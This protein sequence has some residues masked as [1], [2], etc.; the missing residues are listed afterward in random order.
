MLR[1]ITRRLLRYGTTSGVPHVRSASY[2]PMTYIASTTGRFAGLGCSG[3]RTTSCS[4]TCL[5]FLCVQSW[6]CYAVSCVTG[7]TAKHKCSSATAARLGGTPSACSQWCAASQGAHGIAHGAARPA[8]LQ[9]PLLWEGRPCPCHGRGRRNHRRP[10]L[11]RQH[12]RHQLQC[13]TTLPS[14]QPSTSR[15]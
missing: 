14:R 10:H 8:S 12:H 3:N 6:P 13:L 11:H 2:L 7:L 15:S 9:S 4:A 1:T 5:A